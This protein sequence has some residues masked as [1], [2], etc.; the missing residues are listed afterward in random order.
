MTE[1]EELKGVA[2]PILEEAGLILVVEELHPES[3]GS[4]FCEYKGKGMWY[5]IIWDGKDGRGYIQSGANGG[6][7]DL[8]TTLPK[9]S[10]NAF[11]SALMRVRSELTEAI[12]L[13][14]LKA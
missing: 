10:H 8:N 11:T 13:A 9:K 6:W 14:K 1:Y 7:K 12:A 2:T 3:F 4:A 5:R